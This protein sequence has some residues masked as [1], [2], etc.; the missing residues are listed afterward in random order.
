MIFLKR[1][2]HRDTSNLIFNPEDDI[3][4]QEVDINPVPLIVDGNFGNR[5]N[6]LDALLPF[7]GTSL[8][9]LYRADM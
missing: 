4:V 8:W 2:A 3:W 9:H 6:S 5:S 1:E 7:H